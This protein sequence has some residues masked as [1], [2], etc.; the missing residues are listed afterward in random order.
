MGAIICTNILFI[1]E[2]N[3]INQDTKDVFLNNLTKLINYIQENNVTIFWCNQIDNLLWEQPLLHPW[4]DRSNISLIKSLDKYVTRIDVKDICKVDPNICTDITEK[5]II[6]PILFLA[7]SL[8][9]RKSDFDFIVDCKNNYSFTFRCQCHRN[10]LC[11]NILYLFD[12]T[13]SIT[14][15]IL[16]KW[17][18]IK[19]DSNVFTELLEVIRTKYFPNRKFV[20]QPQYEAL[21][22]R[23]IY[24]TTDKKERILYD[25]THRLTLSPIEASKIQGFHDEDIEGQKKNN[26]KRSFR[27]NDVCR[28]YYDYKKGNV[29]LLKQYTGSD[30]HEKGTRHT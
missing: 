18:M 11:P 26:K 25:I 27:V 24:K 21:F 4:L 29:L 17:D 5:D 3:W 15:E 14:D 19:E 1:N 28:V 9:E 8:I 23:S 2:S 22:I 7:H 16:K 12:K 30:E 20:Y 6:S 10:I 13:V